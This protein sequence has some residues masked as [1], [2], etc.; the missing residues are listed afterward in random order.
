MN[1]G[2][3]F[4]G[5]GGYLGIQDLKQIAPKVEELGDAVLNPE[6]IESITPKKPIGAYI[7][8]VSGKKYE[9]PHDYK[10]VVSAYSDAMRLLHNIK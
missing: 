6:M 9:L 2:K 10:S 7:D 8:M 5:R 1:I 4:T 3:I